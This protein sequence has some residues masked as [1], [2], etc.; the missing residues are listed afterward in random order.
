MGKTESFDIF[1]VDVLYSE[2]AF[3]LVAWATKE[4]NK[5]K[6]NKL[7]KI[8]SKLETKCREY[9]KDIFGNMKPYTYRQ[10]NPLKWK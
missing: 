4:P 3:D 8:A 9:K 1:N 5:R 2:S 7:I 6:A 10:P